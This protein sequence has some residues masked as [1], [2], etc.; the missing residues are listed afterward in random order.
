MDPSDT[1]LDAVLPA[2]D[3]HE[4]HEVAVHAGPERVWAALHEVSLRDVPVFRGL[5]TARELPAL[6]VGRRWLTSDVDRPILEQM[7]ESGF[8]L[9]AE[10]P[11][12]ETVVG[13][14]TQPWRPGS[15]GARPESPE[16]FLAFDTPGWAKAVLSFRLDEL[17]RGTRLVSETRVKTTDAAAR[18]AFRA[19]WLAIGWASAMTRRA[20]LTAIRRRA[21]SA[22]PG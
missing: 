1:L 15:V 19:Y 13:L 22:E 17:D 7:T 11:P 12:C 9:L 14:L 10:H 16:A 21:E 18:R 20:W 5:M 2:Y 6:V 3:L 4:V 8:L